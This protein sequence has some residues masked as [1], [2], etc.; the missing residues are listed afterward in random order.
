VYSEFEAGWVRMSRYEVPEAGEGY[1]SFRC[2][3]SSQVDEKA[4]PELGA[5]PAV[6]DHVDRRGV[7]W[8]DSRQG[9]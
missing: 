8:L 3:V 6:E 1:G 5:G 4:L 7:D 2:Q 9:G